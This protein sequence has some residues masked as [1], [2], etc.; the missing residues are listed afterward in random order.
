MKEKLRQTKIDFSNKYKLRE[1]V[2][3]SS[4]TCKKF[5]GEKEQQKSVTWVYIKEG[6][7]PKKKYMKMK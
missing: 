2:A 4:L 3:S 6:S 1:V 7:T 5:F